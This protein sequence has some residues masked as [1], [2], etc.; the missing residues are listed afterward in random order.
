MKNSQ[1]V[2]LSISETRE[3]I[4]TMMNLETRSEEQ[5]QELR[6]LTDKMKTLEVEFRACIVA[7]DETEQRHATEHGNGS[8]LDQE[9]R[10]R[11][12][13]RSQASL[14]NYLKSFMSGRMPTGVEAELQQAAG[15]DGIPLE[16]WDL[17]R[18]VDTVSGA[19][20]TTGINLDV[21]RPQVF[22]YSIAP[23]LAIEMPYVASGTYATGTISTPLIA[24]SKTKSQDTDSTAAAFTVQTASPKRISSRL[25]VT[26]EDVA[27]VGQ[28]NFESVLR[29]NLSLVLSDELDKQVINGDGAGANLT[30]IF[31]RLTTPGDPTD[32]ADFDAF[33]A[34]FADGIDGLWAS[35]MKEVCIVSGP[36]T[37]SLSAKTFRDVGT[38][39]G[40][41]GDIAFS[42]YA[43]THMGA[44]WTNSRMPNP[45]SGIQQAI[46]YRKGRSMMGGGSGMR[47]AV[48][49]HWGEISIDDIYSGSGKGER[50]FTMHVLLGDV[51]LVQPNAY[52][53]VTFKVA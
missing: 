42:D 17:E 6:V 41:R 15:V 1:R 46:L 2:N 28:A 16:L 5:V 11:L 47:T 39:N 21:L 32:V 12:E 38:A 30:G 25:S 10:E 33:V 44:W 22:A 43:M 31:Q 19:P 35:M 34:S 7:E 52:G 26:L 24:A 29:E 23:K 40:D 49:P 9:Q 14:T 37:Y 20:S 51:L 50:Y 36:T 13:L 27:A 3:T 53:Q 45:S 18:R 8:N 48:C 4:N